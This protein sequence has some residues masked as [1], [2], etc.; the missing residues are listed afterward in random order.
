MFQ[1]TTVQSLIEIILVFC[2]YLDSRRNKTKLGDRYLTCSFSVYLESEPSVYNKARG[3]NGDE[4]VE[5]EG[6]HT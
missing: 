1:I 3:Y 2:K 5:Q 6:S 4:L